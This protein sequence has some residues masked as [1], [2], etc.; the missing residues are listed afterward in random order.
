MEDIKEWL[1]PRAG[2]VLCTAT[3]IAL[4]LSLF[5]LVG[6]P[7]SDPQAEAEAEAQQM[8]ED[9]EAD[10]TEA[11]DSL[12]SKHEKLL[13]Q[14]PGMDIE[15]VTRDQARGRSLV[16]TLADSS[17][18]SRSVKEVQRGLDD[19]YEFLDETSRTLTEFIPVWMEATSGT[20]Y[21][22][23]DLQ[24]S[25]RGVQGLDYSY[26]GLARL[27]P[28]EVDGEAPAGAKSEFVIFTYLTANDGTVT[29][30]EAYRA[31]PSTR[32]ALLEDQ[33]EK[34]DES[35]EPAEDTS[36]EPSDGG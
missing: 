10:L 25:L 23:A 24:I 36:A 9:L 35:S 13:S 8:I 28:A 29:S 16:L 22:L 5:S 4:A 12:H 18:T 34:D 17:S 7:G 15:R 11:E 2:V 6:I 21:V 19:R 32:D 20:D 31:S 3:A 26:V 33:T 14:L 1:R 30:L 27:D